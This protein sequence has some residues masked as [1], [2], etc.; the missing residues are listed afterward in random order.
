MNDPPVTRVIV[1]KNPQG[2]HARP[3]EMLARTAIQFKSEIE[4]VCEGHRA[5]AKSILHLLTLGAQQGTS[6][7]IEAR[8]Q[9]A[10]LAV[11][12]LAKLVESGF[13]NEEAPRE[14]QVN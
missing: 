2:L 5:D 14:G 10:E 12:T 13:A 11:E 1:I 8:G 6:L 9:D 3:A 7:A 4:L